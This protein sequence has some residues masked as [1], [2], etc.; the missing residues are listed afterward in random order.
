MHIYID[1]IFIFP[2]YSS[3]YIYSADID[4]Y[5]HTCIYTM[6]ETMISLYI[7]LINVYIYIYIPIINDYDQL[8]PILSP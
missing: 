7:Y 1:D 2:M 3:P 6:I 5:Y 8:I 4:T